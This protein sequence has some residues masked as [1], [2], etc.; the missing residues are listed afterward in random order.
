MRKALLV[1][2]LALLVAFAAYATES[3]P[4]NTVGFIKMQRAGHGFLNGFSAFM[5]SFDYYMPGYH[6]TTSIDTIIGTQAT[7]ADEIW[8]QTR[9]TSAVYYYGLWYNVYP[10][11]NT[12]FYWFYH[13]FT[14]DTVNITTAGEV[15]T[16]AI[17]YGPIPAGFNAYGIPIAQNTLCSSLDLDDITPDPGYLEVWDQVN[18]AT[19]IYY[20]PAWYPDGTII[21][22]CPVWVYNPSGA[23]FGSWTYNPG[24]DPLDGITSSVRVSPITPEIRNNDRAITPS[25]TKNAPTRRSR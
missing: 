15:V 14:T 19:Y 17:N 9:G 24:D 7:D 22:S 16:S 1:T 13:Y 8:S 21:P 20:S 4:S 18:A 10:M 23:A 3:D 6:A 12:D 25:T 11:Y 2:A 5:L